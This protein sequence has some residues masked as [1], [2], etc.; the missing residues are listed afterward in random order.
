MK[1]VRHL[2]YD[3]ITINVFLPWVVP[4]VVIRVVNEVFTTQIN[5][6]IINT[7]HLNVKQHKIILTYKGKKG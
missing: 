6:I 7:D 5:Q 4:Q 2:K 1:E 3:C